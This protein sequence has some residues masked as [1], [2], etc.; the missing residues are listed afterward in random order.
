MTAAAA[1]PHVSHAQAAQPA[2]KPVVFSEPT[3]AGASAPTADSQ[4][5]LSESGWRNEISSI[6]V[7]VGTWDFF[8]DENFGGESMRL[9]AGPYPMLVPEWSKR[10]GSSMFVQP[11]AARGM[12]LWV[13]DP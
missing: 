11:G 3:F 5:N 8:T 9:A 10:I 4:P 13:R 2:S 7:Q 12:M 6:E 1:A